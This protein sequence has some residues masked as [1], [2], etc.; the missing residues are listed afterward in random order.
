M[1]LLLADEDM[2]PTKKSLL[3]SLLDEDEHE[4]YSK[5]L[6]DLLALG[7]GDSRFTNPSEVGYSSLVSGVCGCDVKWVNFKR[8][9]LIDILH[10]QV[11]INLE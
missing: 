6:C 5:L 9:L 4:K 3:T 2:L 1:R 7:V 11:N 8:N 10:I